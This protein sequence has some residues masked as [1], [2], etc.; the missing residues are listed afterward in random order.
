MFDRSTFVVKFAAAACFAFLLVAC[1]DQQPSGPQP[2]APSTQVQAAP[3]TGVKALPSG[4]LQ[5]ATTG[6]TD[7]HVVLINGNIPADFATRVAN[8]GGGGVATYPDI[9]V[10]VTTGLTDAA[11]AKL[12][13][14]PGVGG[15]ERDSLVQWIPSADQFN[16]EAVEAMEAPSDQ[17]NQTGAFFYATWQWNI[18]QID[19]NG[20]YLATNGGAG[21]RIAILDTGI[22]AGQFSLVGKVD[23]AHSASFITSSPCGAADVAD[24]VDRHF[25]GT[26]VAG[27]VSPDGISLASVGP[28]AQLIAVKVLSCGG[29]G[30]F[31]R[32][33]GALVY[34][35]NIR[36]DRID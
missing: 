12:A 22:D 7:Q 2:G 10:A 35:A 18:R 27:V 11:A 34:A 17:T 6:P 14:A 15:V 23:L 25:H 28:D 32:V 3:S 8:L 1:S 4:G 29:A 30:P 26:F 31:T 5:S 21:T 19:A 13:R 24:I 36:A 33:I 20:A 16:L 9:G